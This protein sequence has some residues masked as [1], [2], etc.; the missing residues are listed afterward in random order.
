MSKSI[1][2]LVALCFVS[3]SIENDF[4]PVRGK[5]I[6]ATIVASL[7]QTRTTNS[8]TSTAWVTGD[9][10]SVIHAQ[11]GTSNFY[12]DV[13]TNTK[14]NEFNGSLSTT[15]SRNDWYAVYPYSSG[16]TSAKDVSLTVNPSYVQT[17]FG[18]TANLAG[19][20]FP[21]FGIRKDVAYSP[22]IDIPMSNALAVVKFIV[23][24]TLDVP[25]TLSKVELTSSSYISGP[26]KVDLTSGSAVWA[27]QQ[28]ASQ[29]VAVSVDGDATIAANEKAELYVGFVPHT[30]TSMQIKISANRSGAA[31]IAYY[32]TNT[33]GFEFKAGEINAFN[34]YYD[35]DH[36][37]GG[38]IPGG[39]TPGW[40]TP[41]GSYYVKVTSAPS[42]WSGTYLFVDESSSQA[43]AAFS[44]ESDH[45]VPVTISNGMIEAGSSVDK[46]ALTVTS[47][48]KNHTQSDLSNLTAYDVRNSDG[49]YIYWSSHADDGVVLDNNNIYESHPSNSDKDTQYGHAFKYSNNAVQVMSAGFVS[50][51]TRYYLRYSSSGSK[52]EYSSSSS[53]VQ[54]YKLSDEV[55]PPG[56]DDPQTG[57]YFV[58][59]SSAPSSW[60]GTY[61]VVDEDANKAFAYNSSSSYATSVSISSGK[62][63]WTSDLDN[64][65]V[66]ISDAGLDHPNTQMASDLGVSSAL[67]AYNVKTKGGQYIYSSQSTVKVENSN[68]GENGGGSNTTYYHAFS[69]SNGDVYMFSSGNYSS[70]SSSASYYYTLGYSSSKFSYG[71][72]KSERRTVQLY[73]LNGTS[74]GKQSQNLSFDSAAETWKIGDT[75]KINSTYTGQSV[76][77][78]STSVTYSSSD[79]SVATV[80]GTQITIKGYGTTTITASA[81]GTDSYY[82]G[83]ASYSL[84]ISKEGAYNLEN[85]YVKNYLDDAAS[86]YSD[87]DWSSKSVISSY[88]K[89]SYSSSTRRDVPSPVSISWSS[90]ISG[91]KTIDVY[92]DQAMSKLVLSATS[93]SSSVDILNL[94]PNCTYFYKVSVSGSQQATGSFSTEGRRRFIKVSNMCNQNYANNCRDLGGMTTTDGKTL[95]YNLIYR[96]SNFDSISG[97]SDAV[98]ILTNFMGI[99]TDIDLRSSSGSSKLSGVTFKG[100]SYNSF[101]DLQNASKIKATFTNIIESVTAGNP[102]YIHCQIG[103][104][105]TGYICMLLEAVLGV[106]QKDCSIDYEMTSFSCVGTKSRTGTG[107]VYFTQGMNYIQNYT[108]TSFK[109]RAEN[110]LLD[111]GITSAQITSLRNAMLQ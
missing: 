87:T 9:K 110:V 49:K 54:L 36:T 107:N 96:G 100:T 59:V 32:K 106:S 3:C 91:T 8:G 93:T 88:I 62:I 92:S 35:E 48:G 108:G 20:D 86:S 4:G 1:F 95:K 70:G 111:A 58:K 76:K 27:A 66:R 64:I 21:L 10:I 11:A 103:A 55:T 69:Y 81:V 16:N 109:N 2:L 24:N 23:T 73:K 40:D 56:Q 102:C 94:V 44:D 67:R 68:S 41:T 97:D 78:A 71:Q 46:Y 104:D 89:S 84:T 6:D 74:S 37:E 82:A 14:G 60:D 83:S 105:R 12:T 52:F 53:T 31:T 75:Y 51:F 79:Q 90:V 98:E 72:G 63:A 5:G 61:L 39:D 19:A 85:D 7:D 34:L 50:S 22:N 15:K 57:D 42:D 17:A 99:K 38:D 26:F 13:F 29:T 47:T 33:S 65:A 28:G 80:S 30:A 77:N 43:F 101:S 45:A 25:V 18:S